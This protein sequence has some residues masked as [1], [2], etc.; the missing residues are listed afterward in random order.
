M[1]CIRVLNK[2]IRSSEHWH[3]VY[4]SFEQEKKKLRFLIPGRGNILNNVT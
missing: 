1:K 4:H 2:K 3:E